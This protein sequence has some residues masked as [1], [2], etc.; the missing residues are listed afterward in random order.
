MIGGVIVTLAP[1]VRA[2]VDRLDEGPAP[3]DQP[4]EQA[5]RTYADRIASLIPTSAFDGA[6]ETEPGEFAGVPVRTYLPA[7]RRADTTVVFAHGGGWVIGDLDTHDEHA[8]ALAVRCGVTVVSVEYRR[9]PEHPYPAAFD[10][11]WAV[12]EHLAGSAPLAVAGDSAGGNLAA[13]LA[14]RARDEGVELRGQ[15]LVY[16]VTDPT[17]RQ[18]SYAEFAEG[19][20]LTAEAMH[21]FIASYLPD[22]QQ[23]TAPTAGPL[24]AHDFDG[25]APAVVVTAEY[26]PLRDEGVAY[27]ERLATAGTKVR[28]QRVPAT[29][30]GFWE[31]VAELDSARAARDESLTLFAEVLATR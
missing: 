15:L 5:R 24:H 23:R 29:V 31:F 10:D 19:Y 18:P 20:Y 26:D 2:L 17:A 14:I 13:A 25:L 11:C 7:G 27:A 21:W 30:H 4:P 6:V 12:V 16:P 9:A 8:R 3:W 1:D 28:E 22:P